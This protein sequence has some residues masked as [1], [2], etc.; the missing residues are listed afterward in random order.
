MTGPKAPTRGQW[1]DRLATMSVPDRIRLMRA[2]SGLPGPRAN[3]TLLDAAADLADPAFVGALLDTG[4]EYLSACAAAGLGQLFARDADSR[5]LSRLHELARD[6]RWRVREGVAMALQRLGDA[7]L[8]DGGH[9]LARVAQRWSHDPDPLVLRAVVAGVCEPRLLGSP[10]A[11]A[12]AVRLCRRT[13]D[14]LL[15]R[16]PATRR[17]PHWRTLRQALGYC[18]SVAVAADPRAGLPV[19]ADLAAGAADPDLGWIVR[20]NRGKARLAKLLV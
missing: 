4:D 17:D 19:F 1:R 12:G 20:T 3:L 13:T 11:A 6:E 15:A 9:R 16:P 8:R 2:N 7:D 5:R 14:A 10:P 18:W